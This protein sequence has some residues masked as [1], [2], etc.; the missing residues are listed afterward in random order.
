MEGEEFLASRH[1]EVVTEFIDA[2]LGG[3][4]CDMGQVERN[5]LEVALRV[6]VE[7]R[8]VPGL[9][10]IHALLLKAD[11]ETLARLPAWLDWV[12][13]AL[14]G[15]AEFLTEMG[16]VL[17]PARSALLEE[18]A[19]LLPGESAASRTFTDCLWSMAPGISSRP[20]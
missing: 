10:A 20:P 4:A 3:W 18:D 12:S 11:A 15:D 2:V 16:R 19:V 13:T 6:E 9:L 1:R 14:L 7:T 17:D 5:I 8:L